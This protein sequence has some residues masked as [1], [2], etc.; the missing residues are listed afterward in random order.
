[1][2]IIYVEKLT[3]V[4]IIKVK[5]NAWNFLWLYLQPSFFSAF[6]TF[7]VS[8]ITVGII[9]SCLYYTSWIHVKT[10]MYISNKNL[11]Y[12]LKKLHYKYVISALVRNIKFRPFFRIGKIWRWLQ[13]SFRIYTKGSQLIF[14]GKHFA[15]YFLYLKFTNWSENGQRLLALYFP[16]LV[17]LK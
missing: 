17:E 14:E 15:R 2:Q 10:S 6:W 9:S 7:C 4:Y 13:E 12:L 11:V 8:L 1:M 16:L 5:S 3:E